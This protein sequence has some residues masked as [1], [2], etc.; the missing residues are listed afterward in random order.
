[1]DFT[2]FNPQSQKE[3]DFLANFVARGGMLA[4]YLRQLR[5]LEPTRPATHHLIIAPRGYGKTALLRRIA[6]AVRTEPDLNSRLIA[7]SFREE[8]YNVISLDV[9]WRN[10]L[11]S[12]LEVREDE[13]ATE[14]EIMRLD[15]AW[16]KH[17]PRQA[18][19]REDQ[20]GEPVKQEFNLHC[21]QLGRRPLLLIDN[22]DALLAGLP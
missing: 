7:L 10:C 5:L 4:Y 11:Q 22:L 15:A 21:E 14:D 8:Q 9:F 18:L 20:D 19:K 17:A 2:H 6:I 16:D 12:L 1:M 3:E 13:K